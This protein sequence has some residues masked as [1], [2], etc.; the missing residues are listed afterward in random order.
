M[1]VK[2]HVGCSG[3]HYEH[4]RGIYYPEELPKSQWLSFYAR[5][6]DTVELNNSFYRVPS[7]KAFAAWRESTPEDFVF[8]VKMNRFV[9]HIKKLKNLGSAVD[10]FLSRASVL[11]K[12]LGPVLYQLPPNMKRN[13]ELLRSFLSSLPPRYM[14]TIEFRHES[15]I[16][17]KVFDTLRRHSVALCV[18]DMPDFSCPA[19]ATADFVYVRFHGSEGLYSSS[20]SE[21]ELARW[22]KAI[23]ELGQQVK[24]GYIYFN[25]D[26][27]AFAVENAMSLRRLLTGL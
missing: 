17:E 25:N 13:D 5:Q 3:W 19:V 9:T 10:D 11:G 15:W 23:A 16:D 22:A 14:H 20:Y 18:F 1:S 7:Q 27:M 2:Y 26:A 21:K 4:W 12:K 8:A 24:A 6:F